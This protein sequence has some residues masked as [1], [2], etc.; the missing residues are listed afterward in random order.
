MPVTPATQ[1]A[2]AGELLEPRR[3]RLQCVAISP[4]HSSLGNRGRLHLKGEKKKKKMTDC[5]KCHTAGPRRVMDITR[6]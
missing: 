4:L 5:A 3:W 2:E 6:N 1:E